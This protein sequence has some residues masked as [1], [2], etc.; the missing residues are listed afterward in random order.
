[1]RDY[2][3]FKCPYIEQREIWQKAESFRVEFW[4]ANPIPVDI[5]CIVEQKLKL[6]M[7]SEHDLLSE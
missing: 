6:N 4:S 5:E 3:K 2:S 1:M 7:E